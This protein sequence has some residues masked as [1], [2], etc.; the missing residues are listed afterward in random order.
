VSVALGPEGIGPWRL[1]RLLIRYRL[2]FLWNGVRARG[3]GRVPVLALVVGVVTAVSYVGLFTQA[4]SVICDNTDVTGQ[5]TALAVVAL[6]IAF[7]SFSAKAA[8]SEAVLAGS[9]E[10]EFMLS[11]PVALPSLV[12]ARCVAESATDPLGALFLL[13]VLLAATLTWGLP[14]WAVVVAAGVSL[15]VQL[16][17]SATA[18]ATQIALVRFVP[19]AR[20]RGAW[21]ALGLIASLSL[22]S[23]WMMGTR[24]LRAPA[25]VATGLAPLAPLVARSPGALIVGPLAA[26]VKGS[27]G[28]MLAALGALAAATGAAVALAA[29][30]ARRAG[31]AGWEEAGASWADATVRPGEEA[32]RPGR[33]LTAA[34]KDLALITRDR[35]RLLTLVSMPVIFVGVQLFGTAG[36]DWSTATLE[37]VSHVAF[38]L[39]L[40]MVTIGPLAHMQAERRAFWIMRAVPVSVGRLLAAKAKA[41]SIVIGG[42]ALLAFAVLSLGTPGLTLAAWVGS[43]L[44]VVAGA[45]G[46]SWLSIALAAGAADLS[47]EQRP[48]IGPVTIYTFMLVGGLYNVVLA[49]DPATFARGVA[50]YAFAIAAYWVEGVRHATV[51]LDAEAVRA[52]RVSLGDGAAFIVALAL[53]RRGITSAVRLAGESPS[54]GALIGNV[55]VAGVIALAAGMYLARRPGAAKRGSLVGAAGWAVGLGAAV[56]AGM[57][58][59]AGAQAPPAPWLGV[60]ALLVPVLLGEE[61]V[62]RGVLQRGLEEGLAQQRGATASSIALAAAIGVALSI[63]VAGGEV[64]AP[65]VGVLV[66]VHLAAAMTR[67]VTGRWTAALVARVVI[68]LA[69][70]ALGRAGF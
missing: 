21:M 55:G 56:G 46:M 27:L 30:V 44:A 22:A 23:L 42:V 24:V 47:D 63:I 8:S 68:V 13:P 17:I 52:R 14:W 36:W 59:F 49:V 53:G 18:Q 12:V 29:A 19:R 65:P 20:R 39:T 70:G 57:R 34:T 1:A 16:A 51:C 3:R 7:G 38:S 58:L 33:V 41:W 11:R 61:L 64:G 69:A 50:L 26:L 15:L 43:A 62:L 45:V 2:R 25:S 54:V 40:Y 67:A 35:T 48:P 10:N 9:A 6:T 5:V 31:M 60:L 66:A 32:R 4:F 28:G 37:R